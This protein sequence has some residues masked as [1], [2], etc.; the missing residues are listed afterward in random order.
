MWV[1]LELLLTAKWDFCV[2]SVRAFFMHS[3][4]RYLKGQISW[5]SIPNTVIETKICNFH[6]KRDDEHPRYFYKGVATPPPPP[7]VYNTWWCVQTWWVESLLN[8]LSISDR[9]LRNTNR[10]YVVTMEGEGWRVS[11]TKIEN[12]FQPTP[13]EWFA[14]LKETDYQWISKARWQWKSWKKGD[15]ERNPITAARNEGVVSGWGKAVCLCL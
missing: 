7:S 14:D 10:L 1:W 8:G 12:L 3:T 5:L 9:R 4:K 13:S 6:A 11:I 15:E 2:V